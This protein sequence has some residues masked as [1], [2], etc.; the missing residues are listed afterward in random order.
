[1]E[2]QELKKR[3][4]KKGA[5]RTVLYIEYNLPAGVEGRSQRKFRDVIKYLDPGDFSR[6][7]FAGE[8]CAEK[9][10]RLCSSS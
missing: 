9:L 7:I 2:E 5:S 4:T 6:E 10:R 1:M 3:T 8:L